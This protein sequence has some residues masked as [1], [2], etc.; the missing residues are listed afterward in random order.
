VITRL[1]DDLFKN[2][3]PGLYELVVDAADAAD[4]SGTVTIAGLTPQ[5]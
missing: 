4:I 5:T 1:A 2:H 3:I